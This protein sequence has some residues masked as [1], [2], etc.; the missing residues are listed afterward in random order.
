MA[1]DVTADRS[2]GPRKG[3]SVFGYLSLSYLVIFC[4]VVGMVL[5][6]VSRFQLLNEIAVEVQR[7][8]R[9]TFEYGEKLTDILLSEMRYEKKFIITRAAVHLE[10]F[11]QFAKDFDDYY[12]RIDSLAKDAEVRQLTAQIGQAHRRYVYLVRQEVELLKT[13]QS[14]PQNRYQNEKDKAVTA[15]LGALEQIVLSA[16][17]NVDRR[18]SQIEFATARA[19]TVW[20]SLTGSFLLLGLAV[21]FLITRRITGPIGLLKQKARNITAGDLTGDVEPPGIPEIRE[22]AETF[23]VMCE[24]L[25]NLDKVKSEFFFSLSKKLCAPL[26]SIKERIEFLIRELGEV[27]TADQKL[28]MTILR[29]ESGQ[30]VNIVSSMAELSKMESGPMAYRFEPVSIDSLIAE[31]LRDIAPLAETK[32]VAVKRE[33]C[34]SQP[35]V[36]VDSAKIAQ[37]LRALVGNMLKRTPAGGAVTVSS[38]RVE[39]GVEITIDGTKPE[40]AESASSLFASAPAPGDPADENGIELSLDWAKHIID[41]HGGQLW[42]ESNSGQKSRWSFVLPS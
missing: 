27:L 13:V 36:K 24:K 31:T 25:R 22:L 15:A 8:D 40:E 10:Q 42:N 4:L 29:E 2:E 28:K 11:D 1:Q 34:E 39:H 7:V 26:T 33:A 16:Q 9:R 6:A 20:L 38:K 19:R 41:S 35:A 37:V 17:K 5:Y 18:L 21:S 3:L 14:H 12:Q 32:S 30:L 23:N